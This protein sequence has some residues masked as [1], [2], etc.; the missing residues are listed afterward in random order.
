LALCSKTTLMTLGTS[1]FE[2]LREGRFR[3]DDWHYRDVT[4]LCINDKEQ[5]RQKFLLLLERGI[6]ERVFCFFC[7]TIHGPEKGSL[8]RAD[9]SKCS[10]PDDDTQFVYPWHGFTFS[11]VYMAMKLH[12][13]R[14]DNRSAMSRL[15]GTEVMYRQSWTYERS[16]TPRIIQYRF[17]LHTQHWIFQPSAGSLALLIS[18]IYLKLCWH[19]APDNG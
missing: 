4:D 18:R 15:S 14:L 13:L 8:S 1:N 2:E 12:C 5:A 16:I 9:G 17:H 7:Q 11:R 10:Q 19:F 3:I 6:R